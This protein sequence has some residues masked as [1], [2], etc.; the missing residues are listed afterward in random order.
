MFSVKTS[1][2]LSPLVSLPWKLEKIPLRVRQGS[3]LTPDPRLGC[4]VQGSVSGLRKLRREID[5]DTVKAARLSRD[6][7]SND[8]DKEHG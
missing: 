3:G 7:A 8:S 4:E 1:P 5:Y 6:H 2:V